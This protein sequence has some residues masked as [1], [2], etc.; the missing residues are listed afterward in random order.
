MH[1][2]KYL[3]ERIVEF[4]QEE[5]CAVTVLYI[6]GGLRADMIHAFMSHDNMNVRILVN[7]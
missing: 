6:A 3:T 2:K 7:M 5:G 1:S 4:F